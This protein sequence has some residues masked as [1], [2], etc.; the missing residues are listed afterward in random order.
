MSER[1]VFLEHSGIGN[2]VIS[3]PML[4]AIKIAKP[5]C[6][7]IVIAWQRSSR[8]LADCSYIDLL[9]DIER[10]AGLDDIDHL[11]V[12]FVGAL[13]QAVNYLS[14]RAKNVIK[15]DNVKLPP[16]LQHEAEYKMTF[17]RRLGF[18]GEMPAYNIGLK[19]TYSGI[20]AD[21]LGTLG[22]DPRQRD[23][24]FICI[25]AAYLKSDQW[26]MKHWGNE[27]YADLIY[28]IKQ[29]Y[30]NLN[31]VFVGSKE[32]YEDAEWINNVL[33][34][35]GEK[36]VNMCGCNNNILY[37]AEMI[38]QSV[39]CIGN[40]GG[41]MHI[42]AA[43]KIPTVTIFTFTNPIKNKPLSPNGRLVM[44]ECDDRINCQHGKWNNCQV[45]GC[46]NPPVE[47]AYQTTMT[48]LEEVLNEKPRDNPG[49]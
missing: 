32:D 16:Y 22:M 35:R 1:I 43:L 39:L 29:Q 41:L 31:I 23:C 34:N 25:N 14:A 19:N 48:L 28:K 4:Q 40:D 7:L 13:P 9:I 33:I 36:A 45:N 46:L 2:L 30:S 17:A 18:Q 38:S 3:T 27:N 37:T 8:I 12:S 24:N 26:P 6:E 49:Q 10:F 44:T 47:K 5:D 20:V 21:T 42:A 11:I 15:L